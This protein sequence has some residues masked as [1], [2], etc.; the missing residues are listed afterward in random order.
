MTNR[1]FFIAGGWGDTAI[2]DHLAAL[3]D[4]LVRR[5]HRVVIL[6]DH[7][8]RNLV[9]PDT[10]PAIYT[11]PSW[12]P[13]GLRDALFLA[14]LIRKYRPDGL[15]ANF[16]AVNLMMMVGKLTA[17]PLRVSW[18][19]T[20]STQV[21]ADAFLPDWKIALLRLR[22]QL[23][24]RAATHLIANSQATA[25][26]LS[27][28]YH[29]PPVK[30]KLFYNDLHDPFDHLSHIS[31]IS[32]ITNKIVCAGR[33]HPSKGQETL[34]RALPLLIDIPA[35]QV[36]FVGDGSEKARYLAL[37]Q[38]LGVSA[39]CQFTG[40]VTHD[41]VFEKM[42]QAS[43]VIVPSIDEAFGY[44]CIESLSVGTPVV[45]SNVGGLREILRD[46]R[47]G[48]LVPPSDPQALADAIRKVL[49]QPQDSY[50]SMSNSA[51]QRFLDTFE[52]SKNITREADWLEGLCP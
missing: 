21:D 30:I 37:A 44:V 25:H 22:K 13:A 5:G 31:Q 48:Y 7:Q 46:G 43:L 19:Q 26:D 29:V 14:G 49:T 40:S 35:L 33:L 51:R 47:D 42:A 41:T 11:W 10:N 28:A 52:I 24:F 8:R 2:K 20:L 17:V 4:E 15:V 32:I 18:Q 16:G 3:A 34:L 23:V 12:R 1:C 38:E 50:Q 45:A 36:E 9:S 27:G 39:I 6:V